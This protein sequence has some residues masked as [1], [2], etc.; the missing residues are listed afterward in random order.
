MDE[1]EFVT[2]GLGELIWDVLPEGKQLGG[3]PTN[4]AYIS[5]LVGDRS[6]VATRVGTDAWGSEAV[7]RLDALGVETRYVQRDTEHP[8]GT[9]RVRLDARGEA[10]F[11]VNQNSAWDYLAWTRE[12]QELAARADAVCFGTLGQRAPQARAVISSFLRA[13]RP[14]ALRVFDV[15][16]RH[17]FFDASMLADSLTLARVVKLNSDELP[18]V[19]S[20]LG[21]DAAGDEAA[22]SLQLLRDFSLDVVAVTRGARGSLLFSR[23]EQVEHEGFRVRVADTIGAGDAF[24]AALTHQLLRRAPLERASRAANWTGAWVAGRCG[25]TPQVDVESFRR[26]YERQL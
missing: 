15:N 2:V 8:T 19:A 24:A 9:V 16:L 26:E 18:L 12:W 7:M 13:T 6:T 21:L 14:A 4:F 3:A 11:E 23:D 17:S 25:A 22:L 5:R 10:T 1:Q 20:M